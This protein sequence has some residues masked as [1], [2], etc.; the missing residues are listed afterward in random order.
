MTD[1]SNFGA[2]PYDELDTVKDDIAKPSRVY[3][4]IKGGIVQEIYSNDNPNLEVVI[5]DL[6][7]QDEEEEKFAKEKIAEAEQH[8]HKIYG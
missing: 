5:L 4:V 1:D 2:G 7:M 3:L 8:F 6:D